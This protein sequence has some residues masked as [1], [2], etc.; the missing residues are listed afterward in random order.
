MPTSGCRVEFCRSSFLPN[1]G[2]L[3]SVN[4]MLDPPIGVGETK[5]SFPEKSL[6]KSLSIR[7]RGVIDCVVWFPLLLKMGFAGTMSLGSDRFFASKPTS[8]AVGQKEEV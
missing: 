7:G 3:G 5:T 4:G 2:I 1:I 6:S 8:F